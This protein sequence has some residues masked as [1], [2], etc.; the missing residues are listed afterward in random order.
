MIGVAL[1]LA[2]F[3]CAVDPALEAVAPSTLTTHALFLRTD[4]SLRLDG[5]RVRIGTLRSHLN[6][7]DK[8]LVH[9]SARVAYGELTRVMAELRGDSDYS[10]A[11]VN[12]GAAQR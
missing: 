5:R 1:A 12:D 7:G 3:T 6:R 11:L 8:I 9:A 10:V 4:G 2:A